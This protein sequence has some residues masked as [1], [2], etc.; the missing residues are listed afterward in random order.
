ME[1][2]IAK[3]DLEIVLELEVPA[4][5]TIEDIGQV[6]DG[7]GHNFSLDYEGYEIRDE[8]IINYDIEIPE[9]AM[10]KMID[11]I[12]NSHLDRDFNKLAFKVNQLR[13]FL[14]MNEESLNI[15]DAVLAPRK[16]KLHIRRG[17]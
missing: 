9:E 5:A 6:I 16:K 12:V 4:D 2:K 15:E 10:K 7:M 14:S 1:M 17:D 3:V 13:T 11:D 8:E